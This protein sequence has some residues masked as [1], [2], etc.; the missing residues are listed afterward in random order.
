MTEE[1]PL[2]S[3]KSVIYCDMDG[4]L[5]DFSPEAIDLC[6]HILDKSSDTEHYN[7]S[8]TIR[9]AIKRIQETQGSDWRPDTRGDLDGGPVQ[10]L[11]PVAISFSPG[12]FFARLKPLTDAMELLWPYVNNSNH[13]VKL[14]S[15]PIYTWRGYS[16]EE[17]ECIMTAEDGKKQWAA[18]WLDPLPSEV[19]VTPARNKSNFAISGEIPN[20]LIDD[21]DETIRDW[22]ALG[23]IGVLH[24]IGGSAET[25]EKLR[26]AGITM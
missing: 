25:I 23:G 19:I 16:N 12:K 2:A 11:Y 17:A 13:E 18:E 22:N 9:K 3:S 14:L 5:A 8:R 15:A 10:K 21:R 24:T 1:K 26:Q 4:V 20:I 7:K 6:N